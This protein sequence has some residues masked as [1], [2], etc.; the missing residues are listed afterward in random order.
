L[1]APTLIFG[2]VLSAALPYF[3]YADGTVPYFFRVTGGQGTSY[4]MGTTHAGIQ[5]SEY[6]IDVAK[7]ISAAKTLMV[8]KSI[9]YKVILKWE[10][11]FDGLIEESMRERKAPEHPL[12]AVTLEAYIR[13]GIPRIIAEKTSDDDC[14]AL[15]VLYEIEMAKPLPLDFQVQKVALESGVKVL[16]LDTDELRTQSLSDRKCSL[17]ETFARTSPEKLRDE[18][19][20]DIEKSL[21]ESRKG[22]EPTGNFERPILTVRNQAWI[23]TIENQIHANASFVAVGAD[24]LYGPQG[25]IEMLRAR[26]FTVTRFGQ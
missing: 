17:R 26:G 4:L 19:K 15:W 13:Y 8:E 24:H 7:M 23:G 14:L 21:E 25:L 11:D 12:D 5:L 20:Q 1:S 6:P 22:I 10:T 9:S 2:L 16:A 18:N 3:A